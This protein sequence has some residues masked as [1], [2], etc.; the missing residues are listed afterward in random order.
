MSAARGYELHIY[1]APA[2]DFLD[3]VNRIAL[4]IYLLECPT[5]KAPLTSWGT[6]LR[7]SSAV[8]GAAAVFCMSV[9]KP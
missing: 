7:S 6:L 2:I 3:I 4:V 8:A 9:N 1:V 5:W